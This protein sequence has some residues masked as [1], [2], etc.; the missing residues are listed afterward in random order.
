MA[1][2]QFSQRPRPLPSDYHLIQNVFQLQIELPILSCGAF[3]DYLQ[4]RLEQQRCHG[5]FADTS[6]FWMACSSRACDVS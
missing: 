2:N 1:G 5:E 3:G 4:T 6:Q